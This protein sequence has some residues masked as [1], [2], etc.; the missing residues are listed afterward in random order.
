MPEALKKISFDC[1]ADMF[2]ASS[3]SKKILK[4]FALSFHELCTD[5]IAFE[6]MLKNIR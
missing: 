2:S 5:R 1:E 6:K 3:D 4:E